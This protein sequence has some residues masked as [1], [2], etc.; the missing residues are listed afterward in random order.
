MQEINGGVG[1]GGFGRALVAHPS[2]LNQ[3]WWGAV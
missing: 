1:D 2:H 3:D